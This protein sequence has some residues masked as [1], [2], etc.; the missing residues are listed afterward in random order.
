[1]EFIFKDQRI[2]FKKKI[3]RIR[4]LFNNDSINSTKMNGWK[5]F[6]TVDILNF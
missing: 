2:F 4:N 5:P 3:L 6:S 1:M